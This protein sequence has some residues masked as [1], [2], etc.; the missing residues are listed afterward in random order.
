MK[1]KILIL[2]TIIAFSFLFG[3]TTNSL[4]SGIIGTLQYGEGSCLFDQSF[5]TY[6]P[7]TGY[8]HFVNSATRDTFPGSYQQLLNISDSTT[9]SGGN[10][11]LKIEI[12]IYYLCIRN[13]ANFSEENKF[14]INPNQTTEQDFW[15]YKC[16]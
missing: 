2:N 1:L 4:K 14:T 11:K 9:V 8:V 6:A 16:I 12:G 7:Y 15:I 13:Y 10:F 5:W 3:C